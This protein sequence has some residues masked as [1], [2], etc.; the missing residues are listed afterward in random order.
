V[1]LFD[2]LFASLDGN[3]FTHNVHARQKA[4]EALKTIPPGEK[5]AVYALWCRLQVVREFTSDRDSLLEKLN[6]FTPGFA[7]CV[8]PATGVT[9]S[10]R[11]T[12]SQQSDVVAA[13]KSR[14]EEN[15]HYIAF[16]REHELGEYEFQAMADHLAGIPG[17]KN[18]IWVTSQFNLSP[19]NLK[20]LVEANVAIYPV[21]ALGSFIGFASGKKERY[22]QLRA[23]ATVSGGVA[24][25]DRDDLE[26]GIRE[27]VRDGQAS[28]ALG[29]Y[30]A[31]EDVTTPARQLGVRVSRPG[32]TLRYR[33]SYA[34]RPQPSPSTNPVADMVLALN[35]PVD[36]TA[37]PI[38]ANA[39]R[40]RDHVDLSVAIDVPSLDPE[41][42]DGLWK[43]QAELVMRFVTADG[44]PAGDVSAQTLTF[45]LKP[46]T[47]ESMQKGGDPWRS[48]ADLP[49]PPK[50][51][52]LK[53][54]VGIPASGKIGT[55]TI[56]LSKLAPSP[57]NPK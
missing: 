5:M 39:T 29:F 20:K 33:A 46:A 52:E 7:P 49:I 25:F 19:A 22:D 37:I 14:E 28:Y 2:K 43:T 55:L 32:V 54:L 3:V 34:L 17:R 12:D 44:L 23:F 45:N 41:L 42:N 53:V 51:T 48:H 40:N 30:P 9:D 16:R 18:L 56:P 10:A 21:D 24:F 36:A 6:A 50:A 26:T 8:D 1:I 31:S 27:A 35:R 4:I 11:S 15:F 57:S 38:T 13:M 47:Y